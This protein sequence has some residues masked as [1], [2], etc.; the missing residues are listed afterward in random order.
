MKIEVQYHKSTYFTVC[1]N[2]SKH[3]AFS[4]L[5]LQ[6]FAF[7]CKMRQSISTLLIILSF[8]VTL[9][10]YYLSILLNTIIRC[11]FFL[12]DCL[13]LNLT[14]GLS[15]YL[16]PFL[17]CY[18]LYI[19]SFINKITH[20]LSLSLK[21]II[22]HCTYIYLKATQYFRLRFLGRIFFTFCPKK[23]LMAEG[24]RHNPL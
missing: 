12:R 1:R 20:V 21:K 18:E 7:F 9:Y 19:G 23:D 10:V 2:W 16:L 24:G 6:L 5:R 13:Y 4:I 22:N 17:D 11:E 15:K 3:D 8:I 14:K